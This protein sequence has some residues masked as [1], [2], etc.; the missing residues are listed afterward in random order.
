MAL[1]L[2]GAHF[3]IAGGLH[4]A[5]LTAQRYRCTAVQIFTKNATT[6]KERI[7]T[8]EESDLFRKVRGQTGVKAVASHAS[9]LINLASPEERK[10]DMSK[11]AFACE[12]KRSAML[13]IP[14]VVLHPGSHMGTGEETGLARIAEAINQVFDHVSPSGTRLL[15][16][17][18]AGQGSNLGYTFEQL[19][20]L[21]KSIRDKDRV[22]VCLDTCHVFAAGYDIRT[23]KTY[24]KTMEEFDT[25]IGLSNLYLI[26]VND[27]RNELGSRKDR[28][29]HIGKGFIGPDAFAEI[30]NDTR[31]ED[32]PKILETPKG[33]GKTDYD[34]INL[35]ALRDFI[36]PGSHKR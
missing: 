26:H 25:V 3:S 22:G 11:Q 13:D 17:T 29:E 19:A 6:W 28:H 33:D 27:S 30:M 10:H 1:L 21:I 24:N 8:Q 35:K 36:S 34:A 31:L 12:L 2:I 23:P 20:F 5:L 14:Y 4:K 18:T 15:L 32:I 9:Y 16:E 7:I